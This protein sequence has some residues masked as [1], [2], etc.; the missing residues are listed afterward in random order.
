MKL[1]TLFTVVDMCPKDLEIILLGGLAIIS[2]VRIP[3]LELWQT[4]GH[5]A[6]DWKVKE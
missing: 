5:E 1:F 4:G 3:I 6:S 2:T